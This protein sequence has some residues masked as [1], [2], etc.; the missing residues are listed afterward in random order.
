MRGT[1]FPDSLDAR[2]G[3]RG[4]WKRMESLRDDRVS[5]VGTEDGS[6]LFGRAH[7]RGFLPF[8]SS[9]G[10]PPQLPHPG[11]PVLCAKTQQKGWIFFRPC[12]VLVSVV[13]RWQ[14]CT[15]Y[16]HSVSPP[17]FAIE[18]NAMKPFAT[19]SI[20]YFSLFAQVG[21]FKLHLSPS[22]SPLW[23]L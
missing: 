8:S 22:D 11:C 9:P 13:C 19:R 12:G 20:V 3:R 5:L 18:K 14:S 10:H 1:V 17:P 6:R 7:S 4:T 2:V 16:R 15:K 21:W 23:K